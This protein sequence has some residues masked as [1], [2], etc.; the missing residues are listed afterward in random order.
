[1]MKKQN[2]KIKIS[3]KKREKKKIEIEMG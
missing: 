3:S 1:M 2:F